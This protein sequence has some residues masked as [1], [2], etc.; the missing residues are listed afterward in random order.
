M[1][2]LA[3][4]GVRLPRAGGMA[5]EVGSVAFVV[6]VVLRSVA[7]AGA[8][9]LAVTR[10]PSWVP[11]HVLGVLGALLVLFGLP[12]IVPRLADSGGGASR[13][14][15][16]LLAT[17]WVFFGVFLSLYGLL[18]LPWLAERAPALVA[19]GAPLPLAFVVTFALGLLCWVVGATLVA[20]PF[21]RHR[22]RPAWV[23][24]ALLASAVAL[25]V[26]NLVL[27]PSGPASSL[28]LNLLSNLG[29]V[30]LLVPLGYLGHRAYSD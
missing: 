28:A 26:G 19:P 17:S 10:A 25:V 16:V 1:A 2:T 4:T 21:L 5:L 11:L 3:M 12:A 7:T 24:Y 8:D 14:G 9:P 13:L 15:V 18:V 6:H 29:P 27:A 23:G 30:L 22:E 20:V